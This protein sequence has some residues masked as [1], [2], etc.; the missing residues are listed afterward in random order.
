M[1]YCPV[2]KWQ[3]ILTSCELFRNTLLQ[4]EVT[5]DL[6]KKIPEIIS[7]RAEI[8]NAIFFVNTGTRHLH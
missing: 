3:P 7:F 8:L 4:K 6:V 5:V 1:Q 2:L